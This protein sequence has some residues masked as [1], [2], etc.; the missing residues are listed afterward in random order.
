MKVEHEIFELLEEQRNHR[1]AQ[2]RVSKKTY[3]TFISCLSLN[4]YIP[5]NYLYQKITG[6]N[7][8][9]LHRMLL[10][11]SEIVLKKRV[12][13]IF[14]RHAPAWCNDT[15][16]M[17]IIMLIINFMFY[18]ILRKNKNHI[19]NQIMDE[20]VNSFKEDWEKLVQKYKQLKVY[21]I[22]NYKN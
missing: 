10:W 18:Y 3:I 8:H 13:S 12:K 2:M 14:D 20:Y 11:E 17:L 15:K 6:Q 9:E 5:Q 1:C 4:N 21:L 16:V 19:C 22:N 7:E